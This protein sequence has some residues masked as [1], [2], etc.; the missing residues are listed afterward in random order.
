MIVLA[1]NKIYCSFEN[2][3]SMFKVH[4][5]FTILPNSLCRGVCVATGTPLNY[6]C[7]RLST[8]NLKLR[9]YQLTSL[10][11]LSESWRPAVA[12]TMEECVSLKKSL[13]TTA[14]SV[15]LFNQCGSL[16]QELS[17]LFWLLKSSPVSP[18][19]ISRAHCFIPEN[20]TS[21]L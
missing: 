21:I 20:S 4:G 15:Y 7:W 9:A 5:T 16:V 8:Q 17:K 3:A 11:N 19:I 12:S 2:F 14:S 18:P 13:D 1:G 10:T 6:W